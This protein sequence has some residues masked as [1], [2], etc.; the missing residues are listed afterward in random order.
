MFTF[1]F[2]IEAVMKMIVLGFYFSNSKKEKSVAYMKDWW[3]Y[4]DLVIIISG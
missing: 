4:I 2:L 1:I 3:N